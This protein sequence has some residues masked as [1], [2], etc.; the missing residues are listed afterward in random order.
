MTFSII[1]VC[2]NAG[3][4]LRETMESIEQQTAQNY[5]VI[6]KDGGSTDEATKAYL[7]KYAG[8]SGKDGQN[9]QNGRS[10]RNDE[11]DRHGGC[12]VRKESCAG[13]QERV[14]LYVSP[15]EGIYDAMNQAVVHVRG[16]YVLFLNCGDCFYDEHVLAR[17]EEEIRKETGE[18]AEEGRAEESGKPA[19]EGSVAERGK[20]A[21]EGRAEKNGNAVPEKQAAETGK[22]AAGK[23]GVKAGR[24]KPGGNT[25][26]QRKDAE[27]E[28]KAQRILC[29][30]RIFYGNIYERR[31]DT[32]VQ[33]NPVIDD[34]ACYRNVPCHQACFYEAWL[35]RKNVFDT[36]YRVRADY[37]H[38]LRCFYKDHTYPVYMPVTV[39]LYEGGGFSETRENRKRSRKEHREIVGKYMPAEKVRKYRLVMT[40]TLAPLR[41]RIAENPVTAGVY[42]KL[43]RKLYKR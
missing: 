28:K 26:K 20:A 38:F 32:F 8:N 21:E 9:E 19:A 40:L 23:C 2:L 13:L 25:G 12:A 7:E 33:S 36:G 15:D 27:I 3:E 35:L 39:A 24:R 37:E 22:P 5:E 4:R 29:G 16:S 41:T 30:G 34:F 10:R 43:K 42:Q 6:I 11:R 31:T 18:A 17:V 14:R 1:V